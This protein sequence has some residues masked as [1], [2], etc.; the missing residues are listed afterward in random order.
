MPG[1]LLISDASV[2]IDMDI[3]NLSVA[4]FRLDY[5]F[6]VPDV[7]FE[8]EVGERHAGYLELGLR[9][10][11]LPPASI[12]QAVALAARYRRASR[13]DL[14]ALAR[15]RASAWRSPSTGSSPRAEAMFR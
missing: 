1:T 11:E 10:M 15:R 13:N 8:E 6:A 12:E 7:L 3:G 9:S 14:L 5:R 4:M 2:L